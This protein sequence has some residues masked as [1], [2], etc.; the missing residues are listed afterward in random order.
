MKVLED[1]DGS[2]IV[3]YTRQEWDRVSK[4]IRRRNYK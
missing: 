2:V 3:K 4:M 1:T